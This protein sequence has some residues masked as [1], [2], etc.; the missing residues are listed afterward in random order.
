MA[1]KNKKS[2]GKQTTATPLSNSQ[3]SDGDGAMDRNTN[4]SQQTDI[5]RNLDR[6]SSVGGRE[7]GGIAGSG[8]VSTTDVG[9]PKTDTDDVT[10]I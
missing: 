5:D 8:G 4:G 3:S 10:R 6:S 2:T 1:T 7:A 9:G